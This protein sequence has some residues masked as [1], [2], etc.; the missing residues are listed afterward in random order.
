MHFSKFSAIASV[1]LLS[2][3]GGSGSSESGSPTP[4][5][6][7]APAPSTLTLRVSDAP[8]D[9]AVAVVV[10]FDSVELVGDGDPLTFTVEDT[11]GTA[12]QI[13]LLAF[14]GED[15]ATLL[16]DIEVEP[17]TYGQLRLN[18]T[19]NSYIELDNGTFDLRVPSG[20][21]KLDGFTIS[22]SQ[23]A[24]YTIE[25][26]LRKSLVDAPGQSDII[27]KPRG[28]RVVEND[29]VGTV[30]GTVDESLITSEACADKVNLDVGNAVYVYEGLDF[31]IE[32]LGDDADEPADINE[33]SPFTIGEV[34]LN[35]NGAY[36][37]E[38]AYLPAGDYTLGFTCLAENDLPESDEGSDDGFT[39]QNMQPVNIQATQTTTVAFE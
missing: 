12:R 27:L 38:I 5:A 13:D 17:G 23:Q 29:S 7:V 14:Q 8:I 31:A 3:C 36:V 9:S 35:S 15:F 25:F 10:E 37:F 1:L 39:I 11:A 21:L 16:S 20:Q 22:E 32:N 26:D 18:V 28:V 34:S 6:P 19:S 24:L 2:A 30:N 33:V 4:I